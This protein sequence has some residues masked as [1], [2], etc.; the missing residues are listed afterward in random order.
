M[1]FEEKPKVASVD[2]NKLIELTKNCEIFKKLSEEQGNDKI[3][4]AC[5]KAMKIQV[6]SPGEI[7]V[8]FGDYTHDFYVI[9]EGRV[10]VR[11]PVHR[12]R[13]PTVREA[14]AE[15]IKPSES[16]LVS[17][18]FKLDLHDVKFGTFLLRK[19]LTTE[20][21]PMEEVM[22]L[23]S[24]E[25]FGE[26]SII[27]DKPRAATVLAKTRVVLGVLSKESFQ[28]LLGTFTE[29]RLNDK[30]DFLQSLPIFKSWSKIFLLKVSFYFSL[31]RM[32]WNQ[33]LFKEGSPS[34]YI[35]FIKE[36]DI[37]VFAR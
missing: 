31:R 9:I 8:K 4:M 13:N 20:R 7:I 29:R 35:Y 16:P 3:H 2:V 22:V 30:I 10:G 14:S 23:T 37:M 25:V 28:K 5:C 26:M 17:G 36:G 34:N 1:L 12:A 33:V 24:G 18:N 32:S 6:F 19:L 11:I 21:V 27:G 15:Q